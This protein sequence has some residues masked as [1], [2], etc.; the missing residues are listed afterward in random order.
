MLATGFE[1][2]E[3]EAGRISNSNQ[4]SPESMIAKMAMHAIETNLAIVLPFA[5]GLRTIDFHRRIV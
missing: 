1:F 4:K 3:S 2:E 5:F